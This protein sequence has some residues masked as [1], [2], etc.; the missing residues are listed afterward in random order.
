MWRREDLAW[1][2]GLLEADGCFGVYTRRAGRSG[3]LQTVIRVQL[4]MADE[5]VVRAAHSTA[6]IGTFVGPFRPNGN[7]KWQPVY[8]W[9]VGRRDHVY[10]LI[11]ALWPWLHARRRERVM[12]MIQHY[13]S[14]SPC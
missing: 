14:T 13:A 8:R 5:D 6:G 9:Q 11:V 10:A 2:A 1:L 3:A 4:V 12:A 7:V